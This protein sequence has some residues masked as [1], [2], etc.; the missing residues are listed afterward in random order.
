MCL[1]LC[2]VPL[3]SLGGLLFSE[4][5]KRS[6]GSGTED[7]GWGM[8]LGRVEGGDVLCEGVINKK[9]RCVMGRGICSKPWL[10]QS[11]PVNQNSISIPL[12]NKPSFRPRK[13]S[14]GT[15]TGGACSSLCNASDLHCC[16]LLLLLLVCISSIYYER[17]TW[18]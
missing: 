3:T 16:S 8:E 11:K 1:F 18:K 4:G 10:A 12:S 9:T 2:C 14:P 5:K 7:V 13:R 6:S 15:I 17:E